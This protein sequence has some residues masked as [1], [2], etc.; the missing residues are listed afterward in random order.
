MLFFFCARCAHDLLDEN[1]KTAS[2]VVLL[3]ISRSLFG[4]RQ[5]TKTEHKCFTGGRTSYVLPPQAVDK[6]HTR[7]HLY[8][9]IAVKVVFLRVR[10]KRA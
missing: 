4:G 5:N 7:H 2:D 10:R 9:I 6:S 3:L 8:G 1:S